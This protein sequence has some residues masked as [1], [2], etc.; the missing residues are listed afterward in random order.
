MTLIDTLRP[1]HRRLLR[2]LRKR[3]ANRENMRR[4]RNDIN[5]MQLCPGVDLPLEAGT[6]GRL[7]WPES[8]R[9]TACRKRRTGS[10]H[11]RSTPSRSPCPRCSTAPRPTTSSTTTARTTTSARPSPCSTS[12]PRSAILACAGSARRG[13]LQRG[14]RRRHRGGAPSSVLS[15]LRSRSAGPRHPRGPVARIRSRAVADRHSVRPVRRIEQAGRGARTPAE[16]LWAATHIFLSARSGAA[17]LEAP[18]TRHVRLPGGS[19]AIRCRRKSVRG[20][21]QKPPRGRL[22][23][24]PAQR[25]TPLG[26]GPPHRSR[27]RASPGLPLTT[28]T[29]SIDPA[30]RSKTTPAA[31]AIHDDTCDHLPAVTSPPSS[32]PSTSSPTSAIPVFVGD[33]LSRT[34]A[35]TCPVARHRARRPRRG[36]PTSR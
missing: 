23:G 22:I 36:I 16:K 19:R 4:Y 24:H 27:I 21:E 6:C 30:I 8:T 26:T 20:R 3:I 25:S 13:D 2:R 29:R 12:C 7:I 28:P 9:C 32:R 34:P 14:Q 35:R 33:E 5:Y 15:C 17:V 31:G 10:S 1:E 11:T 18:T